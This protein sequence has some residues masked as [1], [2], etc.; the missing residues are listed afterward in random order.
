MKVVIGPLNIASQPNYLA[1][2]LRKHGI[3]ARSLI[4]GTSAFKY[5]ADEI[6]EVPRPP[7]E[8]VEMFRNT[9]A[10][11]IASE[12]DII[13]FFQRPFFLGIPPRSHSDLLGFEIPLLKARGRKVAYRFTGWELIN[14][15]TELAN[16]PY[17]AFRHGWDGAFDPHLKQEYLDFL[18]TYCDAFMVVDPMMKEHCPEADIV[19]RVLPVEEFDEVGVERKNVPLIVHAPTTTAYKGSQF[20]LAALDELRDRGVKFELKLLEKVPFEEAQ[21]WFKRADIIIDQVLIGWYGVLAME[22]MA[23]GKPVAVY[24][25]PDLANTPDEIPIHNINLDNMAD[26]LQEL[27]EDFEIRND[28]AARGRAYVER[29]HGVDVVIPKLIS[30]YERMM[31]ESKPH[32]GGM[33]DVEFLKHQRTDLEMLKLQIADLSRQNSRLERQRDSA[34]A[35]LKERRDEL[36]AARQATV[37]AKQKLKA[38]AAAAAKAKQEAKAQAEAKAK[39]KQDVVA[40]AQAKSRAQAKV[41]ELHGRLMQGKPEAPHSGPS[42]LKSMR[43]L[44]RRLR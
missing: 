35:S 18:K 44:V 38:Q 26:R 32:Y 37:A 42:V 33:A 29:T 25:R 15:E 19:E 27:I 28:L 24:M 11:V 14:R 3:D 34:I 39:A 43:K 23:M 4:Y 40:Q 5:S 17:S 12:C 31:Q 6:I 41:R 20:V 36:H 13:H 1:K 2:G 10:D 21:E 16:N 30:V 22:C 9:L 8:R 7:A